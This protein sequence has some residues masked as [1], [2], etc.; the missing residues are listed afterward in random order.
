MYRVKVKVKD[1]RIVWKKS[2]PPHLTKE[3]VFAEI[4]PERC[5]WWRNGECHHPDR[6]EFDSFCD[7]GFEIS[8]DGEIYDCYEI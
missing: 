5:G 4:Q 8:G 7:D 3:E 2:P 6:D 1:K